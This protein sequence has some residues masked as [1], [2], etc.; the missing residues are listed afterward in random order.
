MSDKRIELQLHVAPTILTGRRLWEGQ[1]IPKDRGVLC[2]RAAID[3]EPDGGRNENDRTVFIPEILIPLE[4]FRL[5]I[6][7]CG[8]GTSAFCFPGE[9]VPPVDMVDGRR[10]GYGRRSKSD[11]PSASDGRWWKVTIVTER[12]VTVNHVTIPPTRRWQAA[13]DYLS[14]P[15]YLQ[16]TRPS[17]LC[18]IF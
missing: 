11:R 16:V 18:A 2:K 12:Y 4:R 9:T 13:V 17:T 14:F 1:H 6:I 7:L 3:S 5:K 10:R 15:Y 8:R